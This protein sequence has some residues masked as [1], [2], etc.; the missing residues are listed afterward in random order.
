[1]TALQLVALAFGVLGALFLMTGLAR[2]WRWRLLSAG[3]HGLLGLCLLAVAALCFTVGL[4]L[5]TYS[6][7]THE[8]AAAELDF[9]QLVPGRYRA[10]ITF[11]DDTLP[12]EF[13]LNGDEWQV[14]ARIIKWQG[15]ANLLG[16]D[17]LFRLDRLSGRHIDI[18]DERSRPRT[19]Y[20]LADD[21]GLDLWEMSRRYER[22]LPWIDARYG[23][24]AFLPMADGAK[25]TLTVSQSGLVAR[26]ANEPARRAVRRWQ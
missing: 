5:H 8:Q 1:M 21:P 22:W 15:K 2:L 4:N 11:A 13:E 7:L 25:F 23:S 17:T 10:R 20:A 9:T 12:R 24:A 26:A 6:R 14:D 16:L 19:V 3:G 18:D